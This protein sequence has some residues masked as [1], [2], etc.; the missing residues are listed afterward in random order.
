M[1]YLAN[2]RDYIKTISS[3]NN[4]YI[5]KLDNKEDKSVG[6]YDL[7]TSRKPII[8]LGGL[9]N[10]SYN[11]K[12]ISILIHW[13]K[14]MKETEVESM[15]LYNA[16][17]GANDF[18]INDIHISHVELLEPQPI[19]VGTDNSGVYEMVIECVFYYDR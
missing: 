9:E 8:A 14:N 10:T 6:V 18:D 11:I 16:L 7:K 2:V 4:Y 12:P 1:L 15:K 13:N 3:A 5:G 19:D 17:L